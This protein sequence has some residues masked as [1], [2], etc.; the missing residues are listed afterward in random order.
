MTPSLE[1]QAR[2]Y[3]RGIL[4]DS[5]LLFGLYAGYRDVP[6]AA[7][8]AELQQSLTGA[9]RLT[10]KRAAASVSERTPLD[11]QS[12]AIGWIT[13]EAPAHFSEAV[14]MQFVRQLAS[15]L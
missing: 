5:E 12:F 6:P 4:N 13:V 14:P 3:E 10:V 11:I 15:S 1:Q 7:A 9:T 8:V 2:D